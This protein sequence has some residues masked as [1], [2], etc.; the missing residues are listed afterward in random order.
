MGFIVDTD[1]LIEISKGNN[2]AIEFLEALG[3]IKISVISAM[4][5]IVGARNKKEISAIE[6]FLSNYERLH[7]NEEI[8]V[9]ALELIRQHSV[10]DGLSIP[11]ALIGATAMNKDL[12]LATKNIKHFKVIKEIKIKE[13]DY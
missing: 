12:I 9:K 4:E 7:I 1:I 2:K 11:D 10:T 13:P 3:E 5:L 6:D 8:S